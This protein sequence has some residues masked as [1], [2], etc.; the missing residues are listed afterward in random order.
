[1]KEKAILNTGADSE[2]NTDQPE[3]PETE[4]QDTRIDRDEKTLTN[5]TPD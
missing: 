4:I 3:M 2:C 5:H 1:M